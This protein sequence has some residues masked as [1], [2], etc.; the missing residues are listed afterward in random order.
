[1]GKLVTHCSNCHACRRRESEISVP[2]WHRPLRW[3]RPSWE[4]ASTVFNGND[5]SEKW[6]RPFQM[7]TT[8]LRNGIDRFKW[9]RPFTKGKFASVHESATPAQNQQHS[10]ALLI[11]SPSVGSWSLWYQS[12]KCADVLVVL[13]WHSFSFASNRSWIHQF[14]ILLLL[15]YYQFHRHELLL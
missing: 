2:S 15:L 11:L 3:H 4:M 12:G 1:M 6:H 10:F 9:Q 13:P 14:Q 7:A 5:R 8:V